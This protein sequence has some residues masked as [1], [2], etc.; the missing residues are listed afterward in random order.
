MSSTTMMNSVTF[1]TFVSTVPSVR[2]RCTSRTAA[3]GEA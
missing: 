2:V 1:T 3:S